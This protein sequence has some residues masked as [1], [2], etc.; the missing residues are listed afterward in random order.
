MEFHLLFGDC[1]E[2]HHLHKSI[3]EHC[4]VKGFEALFEMVP[5]ILVD[6]EAGFGTTDCHTELDFG[7]NGIARPVIE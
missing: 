7:Y 1:P 6:I 3:V 5:D 4:G 2:A